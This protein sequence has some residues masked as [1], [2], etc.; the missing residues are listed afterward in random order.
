MKISH[1]VICAIMFVSCQPKNKIISISTEIDTVITAFDSTN[2]FVEYD[3][4]AM[5]LPNK[6]YVDS[7]INSIIKSDENI[8]IFIKMNIDYRGGVDSVK[9]IKSKLT[10]KN[11]DLII[12]ILSNTKFIP[13]K[14]KDKPIN[15]RL[16]Y[17]LPI[18]K[19]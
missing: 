7:A 17:T 16:V 11:E 2:A 15:S 6:Y 19:D 9:V 12:Q 5:P 18:T 13:A 4:L 1:F 14:Y 8:K 10:N 3:V